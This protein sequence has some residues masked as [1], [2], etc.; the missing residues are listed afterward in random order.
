MNAQTGGPLFQTATM[1]LCW[2]AW[3]LLKSAPQARVVMS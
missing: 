2:H 1:L 3:L